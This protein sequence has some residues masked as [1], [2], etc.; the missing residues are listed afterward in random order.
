MNRDRDLDLINQTLTHAFGEATRKNIQSTLMYPSCSEMYKKGCLLIH[1]GRDYKI[2]D[3]V[4]LQSISISSAEDFIRSESRLSFMLGVLDLGLAVINIDAVY[5]LDKSE[6][7]DVRDSSVRE[8]VREG[9]IKELLQ[10]A[11]NFIIEDSTKGFHLFYWCRPLSTYNPG[12]RYISLGNYMLRYSIISSTLKY[13][14]GQLCIDGGY[15]ALGYGKEIDNY[16]INFIGNESGLSIIPRNFTSPY[17]FRD[18]ISQV[19]KAISSYKDLADRDFREKRKNEAFYKKF[20]RKTRSLKAEAQLEKLLDK[21]IDAVKINSEQCAECSFH[22]DLANEQ[23]FRKLVNKL[24][25]DTPIAQVDRIRRDTL[26]SVYRFYDYLNGLPDGT[27]FTEESI[28]QEFCRFCISNHL[29]LR[30]LWSH[31]DG[32]LLYTNRFYRV[33]NNLAGRD[34]ECRIEL[35]PRHYYIHDGIDEDFDDL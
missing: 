8:S 27:Y 1:K 33:I 3:N 30:G 5:S 20:L 18:G 6:F 7:L 32:K 2:S 23:D 22:G 10:I 35:S 15:C 34:S 17:S 21:Y 14:N 11:P 16:S 25:P 9:L 26:D 4:S 29:E 13:N 19:L 28:V 31:I 12:L 24:T